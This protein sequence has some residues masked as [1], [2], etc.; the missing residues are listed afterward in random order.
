MFRVSFTHRARLTDMDAAARRGLGI[1]PVP[2]TRYLAPSP[3]D[4]AVFAAVVFYFAAV[5]ALPWLLPGTRAW[6]LVDPLFPG[7]APAFRRLARALFPPVLAIHLAECFFFDRKLRRHGVDR[8]TP[9][10]CAWLS[11]CFFE[12]LCAY[13]RLNAFVAREQAKKQAKAE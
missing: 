2:V 3:L 13:R 4:A 6:A 7:G 12:G 8:G 11:S 9:L 1:S 10:W 5:A